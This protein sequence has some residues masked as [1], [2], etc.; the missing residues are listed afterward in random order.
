MRTRV[1]LV[2]RALGSVRPCLRTYMS[3]KEI[4]D[5]IYKLPEACKVR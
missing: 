5:G 1:E 2:A 3:R 4:L